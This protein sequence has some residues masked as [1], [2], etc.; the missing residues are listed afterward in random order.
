M[1]RATK[2]ALGDRLGAGRLAALR[3]DGAAWDHGALAAAAAGVL[4]AAAAG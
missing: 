2:D 4:A 3:A 1:R